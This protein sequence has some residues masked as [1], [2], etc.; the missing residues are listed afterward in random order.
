MS[1][2]RTM[3]ERTIA[4]LKEAGFGMRPAG[5]FMVTIFRVADGKKFGQIHRH[6][7]LPWL[8]GEVVKDWRGDKLLPLEQAK[9][10]A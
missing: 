2:K 1:G 7:V 10:A 6:A 3:V 4:Q 8:R 9:V 5:P